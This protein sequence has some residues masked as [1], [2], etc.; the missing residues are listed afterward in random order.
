MPSPRTLAPSHLHTESRK[1]LAFVG[2]AIALA[3]VTWATAPR[4]RT[5]AL[6]A[7][8]GEVLFPAFRDPNAATSLEVIQF[9]QQNASIK[10]LKVQNRDGRWT[11]P[12]QYNYPT[13]ARDR[14]AKTAA[15]II[16]L[17]RDDVAR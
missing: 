1:T 11:I 12:S 2:A 4:L 7:D 3:A 8:R 17:R 6:L 5:P 16:A 10:P 14:L 13:D 15:A 9:D